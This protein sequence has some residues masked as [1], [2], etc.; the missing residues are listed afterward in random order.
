MNRFSSESPELTRRLGWVSGGAIL[1]GTVIGTGIFLV[2]STIARE[3]GSAEGVFL[4]WLVGGLLSLAGALSYAELGAAFPEAGGEYAFLRH[5]YGPFWGFLFGWQQIVIGKTGSIASIATAFALFLGY[6]FTQMN[7]AVLSIEAGGIA[8]SLSGIQLAALSGIIALTVMNYFS[9]MVGAEVQSLL[10]AIK[11]GAILLLAAVALGSGTGSW[12]HL[13]GAGMKPPSGITPAWLAAA[14]ALAPA[15]W[16]YDGWNNLTMVGAELRD[17]QRI[18]PRILIFGMLGVMAVYIL[19]NLAYLYVL[20]L[21][22]LGHSERVAQDVAVRVLGE[23]GGAAITVAALIST[24]ASL[25]GAILTGGRISY[26]MARDGLFFRRLAEVHPVHHTPTRAL[27]LQGLMACGLVLALGNDAHAFERLFSYAIFGVWA[28]YGITALGVI[29]LRFRQPDL[30]RPFRTPVYPW[31]PLA[32]GLVAAAFCASVAIRHPAD[33]ALG[34]A[35]LAGG[36][37]FY[38]YWRFRMRDRKP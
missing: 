15:L 38:G 1:I 22:I 16:A 26:A 37:P 13:N 12:T 18:I 20:P 29:V 36:L 9:L 6:F 14:A 30:P 7:H 17:P 28:F 32:F 21:D 31:V 24:L 11:I 35:L 4:V 27:L 33:T 3:A 34:L 5:A 10:T 19:A 25:N 23:R 8:L 2:P